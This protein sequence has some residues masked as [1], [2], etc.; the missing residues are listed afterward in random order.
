MS[1]VNWVGCEIVLQT[2]EDAMRECPSYH[3]RCRI[4]D[5]TVNVHRPW[6]W[7]EDQDE[8][9]EISYAASA[10]FHCAALR[11][12]YRIEPDTRVEERQL[13]DAEKKF[14]QALHFNEHVRCN[15]DCK[16]SFRDACYFGV[17]AVWCACNGVQSEDVDNSSV[18]PYL[19]ILFQDT[20]E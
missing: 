12:D 10:V 13:L 17:D 9:T 3:E 15:H 6:Y 19:R 8:L 5:T 11:W 16:L 2:I 7:T 1:Y 14:V 18:L 20:E 4:Y